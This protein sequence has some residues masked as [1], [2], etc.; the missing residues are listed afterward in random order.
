MNV[1]D[2]TPAHVGERVTLTHPNWT[3]TGRLNGVQTETESVEDRALTDL[4]STPVPGR[5][6]TIVA[7]GPWYAGLTD[8]SR[9]DVRFAG[10]V[11]TGKVNGL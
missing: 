6:T 11:V 5:T 8:P 10:G 3:V 4:E 2:L 9:V 7:V 1:L